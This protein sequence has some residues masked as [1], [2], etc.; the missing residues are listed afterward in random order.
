MKVNRVLT[1]SEVYQINAERGVHDLPPVDDNGKMLWSLALGSGLTAAGIA[2]EEAKADLLSEVPQEQAQQLQDNWSQ[3][4]ANAQAGMGG[5]GVRSAPV[6]QDEEAI[7]AAQQPAPTGAD[8][9]QQ[10][11]DD[12][13]SGIFNQPGS[14]FNPET[15]DVIGDVGRGAFDA[16]TGFLGDMEQM[17]VGGIMQGIGGATTWEDALKMIGGGLGQ[18]IINAPEG[19]GSRFMEGM[20]NYDPAFITSGEV[21][22]VPGMIPSFGT[23]DEERTK[24]AKMLG[25]FFAPI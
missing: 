14:F 2:P 17:L 7:I 8:L 5:M 12:F 10:A 23:Q 19:R 21:G 4:E 16:T 13:L 22:Q 11:N 1:P 15:Y 20:K 24:R 25:G 18:E 9:M 6:T 3:I